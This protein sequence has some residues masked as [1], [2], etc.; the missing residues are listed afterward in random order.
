MSGLCWCVM[1]VAAASA[2]AAAAAAAVSDSSVAMKTVWLAGRNVEVTAEPP[3]WDENGYMM[4]FGC[5]GRFG[6]QF[7]YLLGTMD[8]A[9]KS[10]RTLIIAPWVDY[11][12]RATTGQ[13]P[14]FPWFKEYFRMDTMAD[15]NGGKVIDAADFIYHFRGKWKAATAKE[16]DGYVGFCSYVKPDA[17]PG[18]QECMT[19]SAPKGPFWE[20]LNITFDKI[21]GP[22]G[23]KTPE[24]IRTFEHPV[25]AMDCSPGKYPAPITLDPLSRYLK[26]S[27]IVLEPAISFIKDNLERPFVAMH[28]RHAFAKASCGFSA[29]SQCGHF[30]GPDDP[31]GDEVCVPSIDDMEEH[32]SAVMHA[33]GAK[34][35]FIASDKP[36]S[37]EMAAMFRKYAPFAALPT[38][39]NENNGH[40][41][42]GRAGSPQHDLAILTLADHAILHCPSSFSNIAKRLRMYP[43]AYPMKQG[44]DPAPYISTSYWGI[45]KSIPQVRGSHAEYDEL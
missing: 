1:L 38:G 9:E 2:A 39:Q 41:V 28:F 32:L 13:Y 14:W 37:Q 4:A 21:F 23:K 40:I 18:D 29:Q 12:A 44:D 8:V 22:I 25:L 20:N 26:W 36:I 42:P 24:L 10:G 45:P 16:G 6:N 34:S 31:L 43:H 17:A 11:N 7:D 3:Q 5:M 27:D 30:A 19:F 35:I 15:F 33:I